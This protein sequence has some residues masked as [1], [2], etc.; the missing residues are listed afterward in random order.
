MTDINLLSIYCKTVHC[1]PI[2]KPNLAGNINKNKQQGCGG[3][4]YIRNFW[5][6]H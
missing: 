1:V 2:I 3:K 5:K 4:K 6:Q